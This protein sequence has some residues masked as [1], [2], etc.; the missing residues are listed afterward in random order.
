LYIDDS[1]SS[2][3]EGA[4]IDKTFE[5][6]NVDSNDNIDVTEIAQ[7]VIKEVYIKFTGNIEGR[8]WKGDV[9]EVLLDSSK[10][11]DIGW[12]IRFSSSDAVMLAACGMRRQNQDVH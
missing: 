5:I 7:I 10:V 8:G 4:K 3:I 12:R 6:V 11:E 2:I 9:K 1:N